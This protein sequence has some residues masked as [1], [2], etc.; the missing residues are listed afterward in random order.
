MRVS[1]LPADNNCNCQFLRN[2]PISRL[3]RST[4]SPSSRAD[5]RSTPERKEDSCTRLS[6]DATHTE[7]FFPIPAASSSKYRSAV[8]PSPV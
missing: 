8:S 4:S 5:I 1:R 6:E 3:A 7:S 2:F